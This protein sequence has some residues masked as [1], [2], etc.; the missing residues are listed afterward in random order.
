MKALHHIILFL[1]I[2]LLCS[3]GLAQDETPLLKDMN[4]GSNSKMAVVEI[5]EGR[6]IRGELM[7]FETVSVKT[8]FGE[9][10]FSIEEIEGIKFDIDGEKSCL[11]AFGNG[12]LVTG[13]LQMEMVR[14][15]TDWG[16]ANIQIDK[17]VSIRTN[18]KGDF[19]SDNSVNG[20]RRWRF[21]VYRPVNNRR[22]T[23]ANSGTPVIQPQRQIS[24]GF[25]TPSN[26]N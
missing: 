8:S 6:T 21:G 15:K 22:A 11:F 2:G 12:D 5:T 10:S 25:T 23:P 19:Y 14:I 24:P 16:D 26:Q 13:K 20:Q 1:C 7:D 4:N 18:E 17:I 9:P 3:P